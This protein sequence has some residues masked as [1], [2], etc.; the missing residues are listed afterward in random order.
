MGEMMDDF[1]NLGLLNELISLKDQLTDIAAEKPNLTFDRE[2]ILNTFK[3]F[4]PVTEAL[5]AK[6]GLDEPVEE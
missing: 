5:R 4:D 3:S 2:D 1:V 6:F